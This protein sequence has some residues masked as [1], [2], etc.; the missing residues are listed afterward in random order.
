MDM[1]GHRTTARLVGGLFITATVLGLAAVAIAPTSGDLTA[2][3]A[4]G[5]RAATAA[6]LEVLMG[7]TVAAIAIVIFPVLRLSSER[8]AIAYVASRT[9]EGVLSAISALAGLAF[10]SV[11]RELVAGG[12]AD[13]ALTALGVTLQATRD[14]TNYAA[15]PIV[16]ALSAL[17]L[18]WALFRA[19][20]VPR[21]LSGW[22]LLGALPYLAYGL[23]ALYD[24]GEQAVLAAPLGLQEMA[25]ALWLIVK[26]FDVAA[27]APD[28]EST[29]PARIAAG[30]RATMTAGSAS[31]RA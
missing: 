8:L 4:D 14:W 5:D 28:T 31:P 1:A 12:A 27:L 25:L 6:L 15:L 29:K 13:G 19:R 7:V 26:G 9:A 10:L 21:W 2:T 22:G 11:G 23:L 16:F 18:N 17:L 20:L 24:Q 30:T 3:A